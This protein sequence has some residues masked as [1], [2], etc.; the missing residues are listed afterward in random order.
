VIGACSLIFTSA[1]IGVGF[2]GS[3]FWY[4]QSYTRLPA[5]SYA[6]TRWTAGCQSSQ[7][8]FSVGL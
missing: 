6:R 8:A 4:F 3:T 2:G 1:G 7:D 5:A